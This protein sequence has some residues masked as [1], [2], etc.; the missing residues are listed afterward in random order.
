MKKTIY[1]LS[2]THWDREW[3]IP[4]QEFRMKLVGAVDRL[5]DILEQDPEFGVF[6]FDGQT[7]VLE[8]YLEIRPENRERIAAQIRCGRIVIGPWY[9]QPDEFLVSGE[10]LVR[11]FLIGEE[12]C[13]QFGVEPWDVGYVPDI[14]GHIAQFP[15]IL[16]GIG[17]K[18]AMLSRGVE[19]ETPPFFLWQAPSGDTVPVHRFQ[20][21]GGYGSFCTQ[22]TG[23]NTA[24]EERTADDPAFA[25]AAKVYID[26]LFSRTEV[27]CAV[28]A[29]SMDHEPPH[30]FTS[31]Y[32][33]RLRELYPDCEV[34]HVNM[35]EM[36]AALEEYRDTLPVYSGEL[37]TSSKDGGMPTIWHT[38]SSRIGLKQQNNRCEALLE[39][40]LEPAL[41]YSRSRGI[42]FPDSY[43]KLA[44]KYL[45][46]NHP[47]DSICGCSRDQVHQDMLYRFSQAEGIG[48]AMLI[49]AW[50]RLVGSRHLF[51]AEGG[52]INLFN[53]SPFR[54][55]ETVVVEIPF[56]PEFP[57]YHEPFHYEDIHK[58][59]LY[60]ADGAEVP[61]AIRQI[62]NNRVF[63]LYGETWCKADYYTIAFEAELE[64]LGFTAIR[65]EAAQK[66]VR[67]LGEPL[68]RDGRLENAHCALSVLPDGTVELLHKSTGR[69]YSRLLGIV[70]DGEIGDGWNS[71]RPRAASLFTGGSLQSIEVLCNTP[72]YAEI[73]LHRELTVPKTLRRIDHGF[74]RSEEW[75]TLPVRVYL[76]LAK[77]ES[78]VQVTL[79]LE[80]RAEDHR[81]RLC[82]PTGS[83]GDTYE[84]NQSFTFLTRRVGRD[85]A[86][87]DWVEADSAEKN[88][89]GIALM[90][91]K[92]GSGLAFVGQHGFYECSAERGELRL[93]LLRGFGRVYYDDQLVT[94]QEQGLYRYNFRL[95]PL[96]AHMDNAALQR[97]QDHLQA[98]L[99]AVYHRESLQETPLLAVEGNACVSALKPAEDGSGD[100]VVR[101][102]NPAEDAV[103]VRIVTALPVKSAAE[104][105]LREQAL[106][107]LAT[108]EGNLPA[109]TVKPYGIVTWRLCFDEEE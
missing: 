79:E 67:F 55:K 52:W 46:Q 25:Q 32:V 51:D 7:I 75:V 18:G 70:D 50:D 27:P 99:F 56:R 68:Y 54:R 8:D 100:T 11:N 65:L 22:A 101:L 16:K 87:A 98:G 61:Y 73:C 6:H 39:K 97:A 107:P 102:Y 59:R 36:F 47:H 76:S 23:R 2:G 31:A 3:Y 28:V 42:D 19:P 106:C 49:D 88:M 44:W 103:T 92:D 33:A 9:C 63:I 5:L 35:R 20:P 96:D 82:V 90:R 58:F 71:V 4:Y 37:C 78:A 26:R 41:V 17:A 15:Q 62:E 85:L 83:T 81:L 53:P 40:K 45:V 12:I 48:K 1:Y 80:N 108:E 60:R 94:A 34:R 77:E 104:C 10:S 38:L 13:R 69:T 93:T 66:A 64:P 14:F 29:D 89:H 91:E 95:I 43:R 105:D 30:R 74:C 57:T 84:V 86:T 24:G 72:D 109:M 21:E